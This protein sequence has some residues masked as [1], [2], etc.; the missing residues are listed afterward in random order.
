MTRGTASQFG[1][2]LPGKPEIDFGAVMARMRKLRADI[3]HH[4]SV[5]RF[6]K[7]GVDVFIGDGRFVGPSAIEVD[8]KVSNSVVP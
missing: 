5:E 4:D 6:T 3:S 1:I 8:G 7:L 2:A